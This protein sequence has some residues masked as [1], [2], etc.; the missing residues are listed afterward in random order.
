MIFD[1]DRGRLASPPQITP[2]G[3][4]L[5]VPIVGTPPGGSSF[6]QYL[7]LIPLESA[8]MLVGEASEIY[9]TNRGVY[10]DWSLDGGWLLI[11]DQSFIRLIAPGYDYDQVI[12]H[13]IDACHEALWINPQ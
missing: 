10:H 9:E 2:D 12:H 11:S 5:S 7:A 8:D 4:Y 13:D 3:R 1:L 6:V